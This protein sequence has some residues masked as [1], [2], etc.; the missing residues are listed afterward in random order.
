MEVS[1]VLF[2]MKL[3]ESEIIQITDDLLIVLL[4]MFDDS[5]YVVYD[6][7]DAHEISMTSMMKHMANLAVLFSI[8]VLL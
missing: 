5:A 2:H 6:C 8:T 4:P 3:P 1:I 7:A